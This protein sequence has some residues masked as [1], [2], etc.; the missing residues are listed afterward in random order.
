MMSEVK[1][2]LEQVLDQIA[3]AAQRSDRPADAVRL[4][5]A[6]KMQPVDNILKLIECGHRDF[7][8]SRVQEAL[9]K[10]DALE[11]YPLNWH[12]I[13]HVQSNKT[14]EIPGRFNWV[15]TVDSE[16]IVRRISDT[17]AA[18]DKVVNLLLQV[19]IADDPD[20]HGLRP[21]DVFPLLDRLF[22]SALPAIQL[23]GLMTIARNNV[24]E[25]E[26]R[27]AYAD[28]KQLLEQCQQRFGDEFKELSMGMSRD[29]ELAIEEGATM[30]RVGTGLFGSRP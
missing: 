21:Q 14:R 4:I 20:K 18:T 3:A 25:T 22:E 16:K 23:C 30:V 12:F 17:A 11:E 27:K 5:A 13:G 15:H 7:G 24:S 1:E 29:Y 8:E 28:L 26:T 2:Q 6:S 19:N 9:A 10:T